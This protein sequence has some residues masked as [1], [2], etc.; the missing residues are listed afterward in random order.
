M[1][2]LVSFFRSQ[3][4][5]CIALVLALGS[6][7]VVPPSRAYVDYID[8]RTLALLFCQMTVISGMVR[9]GLADRI[10]AWLRRRF[11]TVRR[12]GAALVFLSFFS[13]ML[14]TN[15]V[16]LM[17]FV[18]LTLAIFSREKQR[19][20]ELVTILVLQTIAANI[21]SMFTPLGNPQ[22][23]YLFSRSG[24]SALRFLTVTGKYT[25]LAGLLLAAALLTVKDGK[26][27]LPPEA[28]RPHPLDRRKAIV[29]AALLVLCVLS[30]LRLV[31][32]PVLLA[33]VLTAFLWMDRKAFRGVN[34]ML[35]CTFLVFFILAGNIKNLPG[36]QQLIRQ[37]IDGREVAVSV[38]VSQVISNVPAAMLLSAFTSRLED[39]IVGVNL[40]GLGTIIAS[41]AS[42]IT[43]Q[44]YTKTPRP[45]KGR[46]LGVFTGWN[47]GFLAVLLLE[48][49]FL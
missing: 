7:F 37:S 1:I 29:C 27:S 33:V 40:G 19:G 41:M 43:W 20:R 9:L 12:V 5:F 45:A 25:L 36:F 10:S 21:G 49:H 26:L 32:V 28:E 11:S 46:Y 34:Y 24:M 15:D 8:F 44:Y 3:A 35:L 30:V 17:S 38:L 18:P 47:L 31:P 48:E 39:L 22:N 42:L 6:M 4:I 13:S 16:A 2:A 14:I 23:L